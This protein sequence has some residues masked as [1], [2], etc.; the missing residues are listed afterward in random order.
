VSP[1]IENN[2]AETSAIVLISEGHKSLELFMQAGGVIFDRFV[3]V[4]RK[5]LAGIALDCFR[6]SFI[7]VAVEMECDKR[8]ASGRELVALGKNDG[9]DRRLFFTYGFAM[10]LLWLF[11]S[12]HPSWWLARRSGSSSSEAFASTSDLHAMP[13][14]PIE[15][16]FTKAPSY[17][18]FA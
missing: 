6:R 1:H 9:L 5:P 18:I 14:L 2:V 17:G 8:D 10:V 16:R 4:R 13:A 3:F 7:A 12:I 11:H 15:E